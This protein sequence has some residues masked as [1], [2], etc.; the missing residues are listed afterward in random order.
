[1]VFWLYVYK[2]LILIDECVF[3]PMVVMSEDFDLEE[4]FALPV[5]QSFF[6]ESH[7]N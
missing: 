7:E 3:T 2:E 6:F 4:N 1:M 5:N